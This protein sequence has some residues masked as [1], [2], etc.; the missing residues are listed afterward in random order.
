MPVLMEH[1]VVLLF[2]DDQEGR[3]TWD[4]TVGMYGFAV[5]FVVIA[6]DAGEDL[7]GKLHQME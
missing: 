4:I 3:H 1:N 7:V 6:D 2:A 5:E